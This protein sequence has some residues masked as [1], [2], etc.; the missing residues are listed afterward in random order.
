MAPGQ[1]TPSPLRRAL[2]LIA[3]VL[4][5]GPA[6]LVQQQ[7]AAR[8][9]ALPRVEAQRVEVLGRMG[10]LVTA[11]IPL[12]DG[13]ALVAEGPALVRLDFS[14]PAARVQAQQDLGHGVILDLA[15]GGGHFYALTE[16]GV[17]ALARS[18]DDLPQAIGF[19]PGSGQALAAAGGRVVVAARRAGLRVLEFNTDGTV[20]ASGVLALD[21]EAVGVA[22][23]PDGSRAYVA[24]G[25]AG[26]HAIDL[27]DPAAPRLAGTLTQAVPADAVGLVGSLLVAGS[28]AQVV[29]IDPAAGVVVG[30]YAPLRE[31]RRIAAQGEYL[32]VADA[33]DGLK[34]LWLAA[35]DRPIQVYGETGRP[36]SDLW[37]DG[38]R[39]VLAG[40]DGLRVLDVSSRFRPLEIGHLPLPGTPQGVAVGEGRAFVALGDEGV[41]VIDLQNVAAPRLAQRIPLPGPAL[42]VLLDGE[43]LY[44]AAERA[45][46]AIIDLERAGAT[47][48]ETLPLPGPALD[49]AQRG[50]VVYVA[51]GEEGLMAVDFSYPRAPALASVLPAEPGHAVTSVTIT[52]KRA[53]LA[54]GGAL[55][56]ADVSWPQRMGRLARVPMPAAHAVVEDTDLYVVGGNRVSVYDVRATAEP[57]FHRAYFGLGQVS[58][59][60][61]L[62]DRVFLS[63]MG[64]GPQLVVLS[65]LAPDYPVELDSTSQPGEAFRAWP[66]GDEVWLARGYGGFRRYSLSEGGAL[67]LRG[68]YSVLGSLGRL[69]LADSQLLVGGQAG[70]AVLS[71]Q[72][73]TLPRAFG[74]TPSGLPVRALAMNGDR[75]VVAAGEQGLALYSLAQAPEL[76]AQRGVQGVVSDV[77]LDERFVYAADA[78]GLSIYDSTYLQPIT[79]VR[80][81]APASGVV[82]VDNRAFMP[83]IDGGVAVIDLADPT[84]GLRSRSIAATNRPTDLIPGAGD[85][86][87]YGLA[88]DRLLLI[89]VGNPDRLRIAAEGRLL[90]IATRGQMVDGLLWALAP[91]EAVRFYDPARLGSESPP[92]RGRIEMGGLALAVGDAMAYAA[93]GEDGL[94]LVDIGSRSA[95]AP[96][97]EQLVNTLHREGTVLFALGASLTAWDISQ[98]ASPQLVAELALPAP[99]I[100]LTV[101]PDGRLLLGLE[102]GLLIAEWDGRALAQV[103]QL[104]TADAVDHAA[105][106]GSRAYL[107]LHQGGLLVVDL[108]DAAQP[109]RLFS[110]TSPAGQFVHDLLPLDARTLL[111]SWEGGIEALDVS[112]AS[113]TPRLESVV[114]TG[115]AQAL[116]LSLAPGG[117]RA[118][119]AMG[120]DGILLL[121]M[122][123]DSASL[124]PVGFTDTPG[125]AL[126]VALDGDTLYV[127]DG[128]CGLRVI[129]FSDV[130][131]PREQGYWRSSYASDIGSGPDGLI[132]LAE[133]NQLLTLRFDPTAPA[134]SPPL[135]QFPDPS[136]G[137]EGLPLA[138]DLGW[139]PPPDACDPLTYN[140][141]LGIADTPPFIGQVSGEPRLAISGLDALRTYR[142]WVEVTDRQGDSSQ[143]PVWRFTTA[144]AELPDRLPPAPPPFVERIQRNPLIPAGLIGAALLAA[145]FG[146]LLWRRRSAS[147]PPDAPDWYLDEED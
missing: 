114:E 117:E 77:A 2:S 84:G 79:S 4:L 34:I 46:L 15:Q 140:V 22:L 144:S 58:R 49:L 68:D 120:E 5:L 30:V 37:L 28:G 71:L 88:D 81:P 73:G 50:R 105:Q 143:G 7:A 141:H 24:A 94:G 87:L 145:L 118:A 43:V 103:G 97:Y 119:L 1:K 78:D 57:R 21:G 124:R 17:V 102:S 35:P 16:E 132:Y 83:L 139:G 60:A 123:E 82:R 136:D 44:A 14:G 72:D 125:E 54:D 93:Y 61:A 62:G 75:V 8:P 70:W 63:G 116:H 53:Y 101:A 13:T 121:D 96:F 76:I 92:P 138:L 41:A 38:S 135:P 19:T 56:V 69:A 128:V 115:G 3:L 47:L 45:G 142:W 122:A 107:G 111:V 23:S 146:G 85:D 95:P 48:R 66:V 130:A 86:A 104:T 80:T 147:R 65:L 32:Y 91:G 42:D 64:D 9:A 109:T 90:E 108:S 12:G 74:Q 110:Y 67:A 31:G 131:A 6:L 29:V 27:T 20:R 25:E 99:G 89:D 11:G 52:G 137:Q 106:I 36:A 112:S 18:G 39:L 134:V 33:V 133:A 113:S 100:S 51:G 55:V 59:I 10:G 126:R 40:A 98:R 127:A 26:V 129:D